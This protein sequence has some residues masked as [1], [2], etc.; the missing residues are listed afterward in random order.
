MPFS[1]ILAK[2]DQPVAP[3]VTQRLYTYM[4]C[5]P[6]SKEDLMMQ[7]VAHLEE[8]NQSLGSVLTVVHALNDGDIMLHST[9]DDI[10]SDLASEFEN[11][12]GV[13]DEKK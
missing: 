5:M 11:I 10:E 4:K 6:E 7:C 1:K 13:D 2:L 3:A 8:N 12:L 9:D